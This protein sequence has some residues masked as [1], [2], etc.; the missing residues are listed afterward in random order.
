MTANNEKPIG[1]NTLDEILVNAYNALTP[2]QK[3][4]FEPYDGIY[5]L[6]DCWGYVSEDDF[7]TYWEQFPEW[8]RMAWMIADNGQYKNEDVAAMT[9]P[10]IIDTYNDPDFEP[11]YAFYTTANED[12][13]C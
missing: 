5:C 11:E 9:I 7:E 10:E 1:K 3:D 12:G 2:L 6:G 13:T 8:H 4:E